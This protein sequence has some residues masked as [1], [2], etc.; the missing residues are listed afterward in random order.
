MG[1][2]VARAPDPY[3]ADIDMPSRRYPVISLSREGIESSGRGRKR[4]SGRGNLGEC[5][6]RRHLIE[7]GL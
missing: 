1:M 5:R 2:E 7:S 3:H 6:R 4:E